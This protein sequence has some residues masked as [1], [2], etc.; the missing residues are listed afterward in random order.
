MI[1]IL[2]IIFLVGTNS[3]AISQDQFGRCKEFK[4]IHYDFKITFNDT[5]NSITGETL[6]RVRLENENVKRIPFNFK[7]SE[8]DK[9]SIVTSPHLH[10][11]SN[12]TLWVY[13][14]TKEPIY[15]E[16]KFNIRYKC[17]PLDGLIFSKT[18]HDKRTV[19]ADNWPNR[20]QY[21][22]PVIDH[23]T[24]KATCS[25]DITGPEHYNIISNGVNIKE[26]KGN[27][28]IRSIWIQSVEIP[29]KVMVFGAADFAISKA[30]TV[31]GI[32]VN[33]WVF[34]EEAELGFKDYAVASEVLK[35]YIS[36]LGKYPF[37]K[38]ANVQSKTRYGGMENASC[39]FYSEKS[40]TGNQEAESLI[41]HEIVHQW[42]GNTATEEDWHHI[43]LSE[44]FATYLT[45]VYLE[46]KYGVQTLQKNMDQMR[47]NII[48]FVKENPKSPIIDPS[49][50]DLN[51]L[52]NTNNYDKGGW[53]LHMLRNKIGDEL[54]WTT[55]RTYYQKYE[56]GNARSNDFKEVAE[57][58][59]DQ[60]LYIFF[61]QW[62]YQ[63][64]IP[65][66][67]YKWSYDSKSNELKLKLNQRQ[68][69]GLY[70]LIVPIRLNF[71][72]GSSRLISVNV[73]NKTTTHIIKTDPVNQ[74]II[75]PEVV[76]LADFNK[77]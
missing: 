29:T 59:S 77:K 1:R 37:D 24:A 41:A 74:V 30:D 76:V 43:W 5:N 58:I 25:F 36:K 19:F 52:L 11:W 6:V 49:I 42:F 54:F 57:S 69:S 51:K 12:D 13:S 28:Q 61:H 32:P 64:G 45:E 66:I 8:K 15:T 53:V 7:L 72:N 71:K 21:W 22:I 9:H 48:D 14:S 63:P 50:L 33:S 10:Q 56:F 3:I 35:Y 40:V 55:L 46:D 26:T 68:K 4:V 75:D 47:N 70:E 18:R 39:I 23:P 2:F 31:N 38:L 62:L 20:A 73:T 65:Q 60:N 44:G 27:G 16:Q 67:Q 34:K 17:T